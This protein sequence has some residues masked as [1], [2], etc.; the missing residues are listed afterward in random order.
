MEEFFR[1]NDMLLD[2]HITGGI[3][4]TLPQLHSALEPYTWALQKPRMAQ[5]V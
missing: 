2:F 1:R 5:A 4:E 3:P